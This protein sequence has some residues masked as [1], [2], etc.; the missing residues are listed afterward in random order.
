[1]NKDTEKVILN[2]R[3]NLAACRVNKGLTQDQTAEKL[4]IS[5]VTLN[6]HERGV[7]KPTYAQ[8]IAYA[9]VYGVPIEII[10]SEVRD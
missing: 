3:W 5:A 4:H 2:L 9:Q 6:K 1:M 10:D 8:L 7:I